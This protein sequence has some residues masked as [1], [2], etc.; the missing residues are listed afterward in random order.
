MHTLRKYLSWSFAFTS[1]VCLWVIPRTISQPHPF[2]LLLLAPP[3]LFVGFAVVFGMAWWTVFKGKSSARWWGIAASLINIQVSLLPVVIPPHSIWNGF[4]LL[5]GLG[6]AGLVAFGRRFEQTDSIIRPQDQHSIT[7][8][9]TIEVLNKT[10]QVL[11]L[12][13]CVI[14][15]HWW[16]GWAKDRGLPVVENGWYQTLAFIFMGLVM[17]LLHETG[18]AVAGLALGMKLR[19]FVIGPFQWY[20]CAGKWKFEF[21]LSDS[22]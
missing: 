17:A 22:A 1:L 19:A 15:Y 18:H 6:V 16:L 14:A 12:A 8:D 5:L 2:R 11:S 3:G 9:G 20:I 4:S 10:V 13:A 7:G 21:N